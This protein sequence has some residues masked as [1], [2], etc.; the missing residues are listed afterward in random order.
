MT[1]RRPRKNLIQAI[2][3][4]KARSE[5]KLRTSRGIARWREL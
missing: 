4:L 2:S 1:E 3:G 5:S